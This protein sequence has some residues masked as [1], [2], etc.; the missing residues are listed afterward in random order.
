MSAPP[1]RVRVRWTCPTGKGCPAVLA[2]PRPRRDDVA[3]YC[4][5]CSAERGRLVLR[6]APA[7]EAKRETKIAAAKA[8]A[9]AAKA[10]KAAR[11]A[12]AKAK[13]I[14]RETRETRAPSI[15]PASDDPHTGRTEQRVEG[16]DYVIEI[17][18]S[19]SHRG[20][21][22]IETFGRDD[23]GQAFQLFLRTRET[24]PT[25]RL[26]KVYEGGWIMTPILGYAITRPA[27]EPDGRR[28][29][30][31]GRFVIGWNRIE[32]VYHG[33]LYWRV[34]THER[35]AMLPGRIVVRFSVAPP[36]HVRAQ[37]T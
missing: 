34:E 35:N 8:K 7:L 16:I 13:L 31:R 5:A 21:R 19:S 14:A 24:N 23:F 3:R 2:S 27:G 29:L 15:Q 37:R 6:V 22:A 28:R 32:P 1:K 36:A 17:E 10:R 18:D 12:A 30:E 11:V 33:K 9:E 4:L 25:A 20:M 26:S